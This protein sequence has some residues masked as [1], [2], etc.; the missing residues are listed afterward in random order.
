MKDFHNWL[1]TEHQL[2]RRSARDVVSRVRRGMKMIKITAKSSREKI[3]FDLSQ[4]DEFQKASIFVKSQIKRAA[5]LYSDYL[6][7]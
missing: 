7:R 5:H 3:A 4:C 6:G 1:Q 2:A